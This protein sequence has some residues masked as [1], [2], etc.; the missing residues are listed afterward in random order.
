[1]KRNWLFLACM[2]LIILSELMQYKYVANQQFYLNSYS[3]WL[4]K[5]KIH[6]ALLY[7]NMLIPWAFIWKKFTGH[8]RAF[9]FL[10]ICLILVTVAFNQLHIETDAKYWIFYPLLVSLVTVSIWALKE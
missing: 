5:H 1:M 10:M 7:G 6:D 8:T 3:D 4:D 2:V 9:A